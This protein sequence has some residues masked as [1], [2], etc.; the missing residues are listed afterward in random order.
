MY[1]NI[2]VFDWELSASNRDWKSA[3]LVLLISSFTSVTVSIFQFFDCVTVNDELNSSVMRSYPYVQCHGPDD[4][5]Y[6]RNR[7]F[8]ILSFVSFFCLAPLTFCLVLLCKYTSIMGEH[9]HKNNIIQMTKFTNN[10][11]SKHL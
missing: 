8:V 3:A 1:I 2:S 11:H 6:L 4:S 5:D 10:N 9:R 7:P